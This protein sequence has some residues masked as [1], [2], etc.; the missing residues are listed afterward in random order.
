VLRLVGPPGTRR[1]NPP[2][3]LHRD[4]LPLKPRAKNWGQRA[5]VDG[6]PGDRFKAGDDDGRRQDRLR[7]AETVI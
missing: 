6:I 2:D 4:E 5:I 3:W 7:H 1:L